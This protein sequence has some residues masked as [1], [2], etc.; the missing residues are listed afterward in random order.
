MN[1]KPI[2]ESLY[3][4]LREVVAG[5]G[6]GVSFLTKLSCE[7]A[8]YCSKKIWGILNATFL[9]NSFG[10]CNCSFQDLACGQD[11]PKSVQMGCHGIKMPC[12]YRNASHKLYT[13]YSLWVLPHAFSLQDLF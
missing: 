4:M 8:C 11:D 3:S 12:W 9:G 2:R 7:V 13:M 5:R 6:G 10:T 1:Y